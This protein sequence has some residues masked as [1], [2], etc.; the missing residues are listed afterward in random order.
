M[1]LETLRSIV[2]SRQGSAMYLSYD[3]RQE[4]SSWSMST[5]PSENRPL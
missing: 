1:L 3:E 4:Q 5:K 2:E